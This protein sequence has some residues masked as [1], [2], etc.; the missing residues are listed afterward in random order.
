MTASPTGPQPITTATSLAPISL[1]FTA[2]SP[3]AIGSVRVAS[4]VGSPLGTA[5]LSD[6]SASTRSAYP[7]G[8]SGESPVRCTPP[9]RRSSGKLTTRVPARSRVGVRGPWSSTSPQNSWP[10]TA[11]SVRRDMWPYPTSVTMSASSSPCRRAC[12]SE[13][14]I[15]QRSTESSSCPRAGRGSGSSTTSSSASVQ[16]TALIGG[17]SLP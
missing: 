8:A 7:P 9:S 14:Q 13:P 2:C 16:V 5:K 12:R 10:N 15:P 6:C 17:A 4:S 11:A 1:R 3:T